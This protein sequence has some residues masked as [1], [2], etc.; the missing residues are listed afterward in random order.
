MS[1]GSKLAMSSDEEQSPRRIRTV[2]PD[3]KKGPN[4]MLW[5]ITVVLLVL[6]LLGAVGAYSVG[7]WLHI[8]LV[9][10]VI[11]VIINLATRQRAI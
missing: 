5:T 4:A 3:T 8:L 1:D 2:R 10:A 11:S 7:A 9:L 6:W